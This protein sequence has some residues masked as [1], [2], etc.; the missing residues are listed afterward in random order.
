MTLL[1]DT[2]M[3]R[4]A[5]LGAVLALIV[6]LATFTYVRGTSATTTA[7]PP[8][9][10]TTVVVARHE[11]PPHATVTTA[12]VELRDLPAEAVLASSLRST[13]SAVGLVTTQRIAEGQQLLTGQFVPEAP[14]G[15]LALLI[16]EGL[17]AI[18][19]AI[20]DAIAAGG[21]VAPGDRVDV[22][23]VFDETRAGRSGSALVVDD[24]AVLAVASLVVGES[25]PE[26]DGRARSFRR[27]PTAA[28]RHR[29]ARR[30]ARPGTAPRGGRGIRRAPTGPAATG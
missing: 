8:L 18:S 7:V 16:P 26:S 23:A 6:G 2:M 29:H 19:I 14:G 17:R 4:S 22:V 20:S 12:D 25:V 10:R 28:L 15:T 24:V 11:I 5:L 1:L 3:H 9:Q 27:R 30:H 13:E 21:L